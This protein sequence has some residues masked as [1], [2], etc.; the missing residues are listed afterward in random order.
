VQQFISSSH[1]LT[2]RRLEPPKRLGQRRHSFTP[3]LPGE[4]TEHQAK[5]T[6]QGAEGQVAYAEFELT[7]AGHLHHSRIGDIDAAFVRVLDSLH[8]SR[9]D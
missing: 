9:S 2:L 4:K 5:L 1:S 7:I 8:Q 6:A 3:D